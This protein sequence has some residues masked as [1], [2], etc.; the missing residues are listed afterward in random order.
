M[1]KEQTK[2]EFTADQKKKIDL[3]LRK[4]LE[5]L[6]E[7][8]VEAGYSDKEFLANATKKE[9]ATVIVLGETGETI[10]VEHNEPAPGVSEE[11]I[12]EVP[13]MPVTQV[14]PTIVKEESSTKG[15]SLSEDEKK[16]KADLMA[17]PMI[18]VMIPL[19]QGERFGTTEPFT[20]NGYKIHIRKGE[21]VTVP[22][23]IAEMVREKQQI[24]L[25]TG[26]LESDRRFNLDL[27]NNSD[28]LRNLGL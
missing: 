22:L 9:L 20:I 19:E 3:L 16:T 2:L 26:V 28:K 25:G 7:M 17:Q 15:A 6:K 8:A 24:Q 27:P 4:N 12:Q 18:Q 11:D 21:V 14:M 1:I 5:V 13:A 23:A 10:G